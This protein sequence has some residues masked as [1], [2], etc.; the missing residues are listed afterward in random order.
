[1]RPAL[2]PGLLPVWRDRDTL[3]IG[4]DPRRAVA[5]TG[6]AGAA[7]VI[8]LL[9]GSRDRAQVIAAASDRGMPAQLADRVLTL[10][11]A[12]GALDD[13]PTGTYRVLP[14]QLRTLLAPELAAASLAHG[15]SDGGA[16]TLARRRAAHVRIMGSGRLE[17]VIANILTES[18]IGRVDSTAALGREGNGRAQRVDGQGQGAGTQARGKG[19]Q[20]R[21]ADAQARGADAQAR[22]ADAQA[23]G[24]DAQA[25]GAGLPVRGTDGQA[26]GAD[27]L[28]QWADALGRGTGALGQGLEQQAD[29][30]G[31]GL[32]GITGPGRELAVTTPDLG[33]GLAAAPTGRARGAGGT[34]SGPAR[35]RAAREH[36]TRAHGTRP[37]LAVLIGIPDPELA[38]RLMRE[39]IPHLAVS[40][41]EA[42]GVVGPLVLP[43]RSACLRCLDLARTDR[44]PAWPL[45]LAQLASRQADPPACDAALA[46]AVAAHATAQAL[47]FI[48]R[49]TQA[50]PVTNGTL[51]LVLPGWQWR[52]RTWSPHLDCACGRRTPA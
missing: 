6:M 39:R 1:V 16:R 43:G 28:G 44:D 45:I 41:S 49:P 47:A 48:D 18:G 52:R 2:K 33:Q 25:R 8:S 7:W 31:R 14:R 23:R 19:T 27:G 38:A 5:L 34:R 22:G 11:A 36:T 35:A 13:F 4:I 15:D 26:R 10:L 12:G 9:D 21:G 24:A 20:A 32:A 3:Q 29:I 42:I 17:P 51:E 30:P 37:D 40:A 46:A 50:G